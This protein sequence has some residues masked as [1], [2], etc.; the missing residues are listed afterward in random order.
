[1]AYNKRNKIPSLH[2]INTAC[3]KYFV[4]H[5]VLNFNHAWLFN[6]ECRLVWNWKQLVQIFSNVQLYWAEIDH[7]ILP[8]TAFVAKF[9]LSGL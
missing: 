9:D 6:Y 5:N 8:Q 3:I 4:W 2:F 7:L 1:M